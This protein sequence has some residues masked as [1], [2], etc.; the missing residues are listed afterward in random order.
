M[1]K[2]NDTNKVLIEGEVVSKFTLNHE[3]FGEKF[4]TVELETARLSGTKDIIPVMISDRLINISE[5]YM[6]MVFKVSGQFRSYNKHEED[7]NRLALSVFAKEVTV[8]PNNDEEDLSTNEICMDGHICKKP[9][10]R[11][12]PLGRK[13][14][15]LMIAVNRPYGKSDYIPCICWGRNARF[16]SGLEVGTRLKVRGR[17]QSREYTKKLSETESETRTAYEV[18]L[19]RLGVIYDGEED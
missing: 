15:D 14:A 4:Y 16:A 12:T 11:E 9:V 6:G 13:I 19:S 10:Y 1:F 3:V 5:N 17:I 8:I 2:L 18:S 7:K